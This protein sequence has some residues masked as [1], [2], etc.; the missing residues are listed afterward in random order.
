MTEKDGSICFDAKKMIS[1]SQQHAEHLFAGQNIQ[2][3]N[4]FFVDKIKNLKDNINQ[5]KVD[6]P[7]VL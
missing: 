1:T 7:K 6:E 3:F 2:P 4:R 5:D